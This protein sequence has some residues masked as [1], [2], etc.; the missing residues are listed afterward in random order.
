[1]LMLYRVKG[2]I[3][4]G[5][6]LVSIISWPRPT[7]VTYFPHTDL[8][9]DAF[10]FFKKVATFHPIKRTLNVLQFDISG[11]SGQF[12]LAFISFLYVDILDATGT[13]YAMARFGGFLNQR[14][15]DFE[16]SSIAYSIDALGISIGSLFGCPPVTAYVESGAGIAEGGRTGITAMTTGFCFFIAVFFAPIFASIPP[17]ATGCVLIIVGAQMAA[18]ARNINWKYLGDSIPSFICIAIMPFTYSIAYGLIGGICSYILINTLVFIIEKGSGGR[19]VPPNKEEKEPWTWRLE[20]GFFPQ[21]AQRLAHG[22]KDFW[23]DDDDEEIT[24]APS[25]EL[26]QS[27]ADTVLPVSTEKIPVSEKAE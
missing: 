1:M 4:F 20:G 15:Q 5:I 18:E 25:L 14:T 3:I 11:Y 24:T 13:L 2:A 21:W 26:R 8:G 16:N 10:D 6:L 23:R 12:G 17:W 7:P 19:I 27:S 22:K 9:N